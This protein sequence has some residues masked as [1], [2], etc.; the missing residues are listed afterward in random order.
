MI[1]RISNKLYVGIVED[2]KDPKH[3]GRVKVRVQTIFDN[4]PT[5]DIPWAMPYKDV[6]GNSFNMPEIGKV[7]GIIFNS[8]TIYKPEYI[9]AEHYNVNLEKKLTSLSDEDYSTFKALLFDQSTQIWRTKTDGLKIDHEYSNINLDSNG[10]INL[11]A[12]DNNSKINIGSKDASEA[13]ILGTSFLEWLDKFVQLMQS[14]GA[15]LASGSP[16]ACSPGLTQLLVEYQNSKELLFLSDN[17]W[18]NKNLEILEQSRDYINQNGDNWKSTSETNTF[19][20][21]QPT[22]YS[23]E[24]RPETGRPVQKDS[25]I[26]NDIFE[27][28][29]TSE[30][31][32]ATTITSVSSYKNGEIPTSDLKLNKNLAK[33]LDGDAAYLMAEASDALDVMIAAFNA[34]SFSGKQKITFT[35]GYRSLKRQQALY[36]KYGAGRAAKPGTSNH[37]WGIAIDMYWGVRTSMFKDPS[38]R[39][40]GYKHPNYIWFLNNGWKWGWINPAK[41]RDNSGTDEWW[42]WEY[43]P[44]QKGINPLVA[45]PLPNEYKGEFTASDIAIIK[46][47]GGSYV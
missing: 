26:P 46:G 27:K 7:V 38:K 40:S 43:H 31:A 28:T 37:G 24:K 45:N 23:P 16:V 2:N 44:S 21:I 42:H 6:N 32:G 18:L 11:N 22:T 8:G 39:P 14:N 3:L 13:A 10:N 36:E 17:V 47:A 34:S 33:N 12:R 29:I 9:Y 20:S 41:L 1:E 19:S 35:D 5:A 30:A 4:I 25:S 15:F